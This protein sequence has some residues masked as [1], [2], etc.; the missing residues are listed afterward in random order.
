MLK[1]FAGPIL[2]L[3]AAMGMMVN[4]AWGQQP[5]SCKDRLPQCLTLASV[6]SYG[7]MEGG[8]EERVGV[9]LIL[10][11]SKKTSEL[12]VFRVQEQTKLIN[13]YAGGFPK[14]ISPPRVVN[15]STRL[16][17]AIL[18]V[19]DMNI[20]G[21]PRQVALGFVEVKAADGKSYRVVLAA[22]QSNTNYQGQAE[23]T[24]KE[25]LK[26]ISPPA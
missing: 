15:I 7:E 2:T 17:L 23:E 25:T 6:P 1:V 20:N 14:T 5:V 26:L 21:W 3:A 9:N 8:Y 11:I 16:G 4:A 22:W 13:A 19:V 12:D 24:L 10:R 18:D